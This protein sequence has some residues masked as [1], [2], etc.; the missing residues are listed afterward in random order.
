M[1]TTLRHGLLLLLKHPDV[2]AKIQEEIDRVIGGHQSPC[3]QDKSHMPYTD[4]VVHE[5]QRCIDLV[6]IN[7]PHAVTCDIKLR[8]YL[9]PK[10]TTALMLLTSVLH[11]GK[12]FPNPEV[13][14]PGHFLDEGGNFRKSDYFMAFSAGNKIHFLHDFR[15]QDAY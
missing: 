13:L 5:I 3:M 10:G 6:P 8:N 2:T 12:E 11:D 7:L 1:S 15:G 9:I 14:D 4:A